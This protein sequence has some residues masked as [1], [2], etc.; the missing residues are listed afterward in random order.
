MR[1]NEYMDKIL[2]VKNLTVGYGNTPVVQN[3]S[4]TLHKG[5]IV[6]LVGESGCGKSTFLRTL[7]MLTDE[8]AHIMSG[9]ITFEN[10]NLADMTEEQL[11]LIRGQDIS[12]VFQ[13]SAEACNPV[14]TIGYHFWETMNCHGEKH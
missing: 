7:M 12:M 9:T 3:A 11:R 13:N 5:E 4:M 2:E 8:N 10:K 1:E 6:G 14:Q